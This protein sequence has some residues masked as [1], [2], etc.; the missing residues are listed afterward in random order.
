MRRIMLALFLMLT[1]NALSAIRPANRY[2]FIYLDAN[3]GTTH[4]MQIAAPNVQEA[5]IIYS[6]PEFRAEHGEIIEVC[7]VGY[8]RCH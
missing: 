5:V 2:Q 8:F 6:A 3:D 4:R 1:A 7:K